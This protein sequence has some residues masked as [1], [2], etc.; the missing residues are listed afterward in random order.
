MVAPLGLRLGEDG[1]PDGGLFQ[2]GPVDAVAAVGGKEDGV[3]GDEVDGFYDIFDAES[4]SS[5][6][7]EDPF[8]FVL[9]VPE[10]FGRGLSM[11]DDALD[12]NAAVAELANFGELL[13][14][15]VFGKVVEEI[16]EG[17]WSAVWRIW[18]HL[19]AAFGSFETGFP[20]YFGL[21]RVGWG[22][23]LGRRGCRWFFGL[24]GGG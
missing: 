7:D 24:R 20:F 19:A 21:S 11:G 1:E 17:A 6:E 16:A 4:G 9:V 23:L 18:R 13:L 12:A 15:E 2:G 8:V 14:G 10:A 5:G 3:A 22:E